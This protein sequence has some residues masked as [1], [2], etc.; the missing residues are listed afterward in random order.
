MGAVVPDGKRA[1]NFW[2]VTA[3]LPSGTMAPTTLATLGSLDP[4]KFKYQIE[5]S[6]ISA[7]FSKI[8]FSDFWNNAVS[9]QESRKYQEALVRGEKTLPALPENSQRYDLQT[10]QTLQGY[11]VPLFSARGVEIDGSTASLYLSLIH[12]SEPTRPY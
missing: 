9:A 6:P 12:I 11:Q 8:T 3:R 5:F 4:T 2:V 10:V 7:G 1:V